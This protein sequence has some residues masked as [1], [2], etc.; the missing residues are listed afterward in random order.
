VDFRESWNLVR[1]HWVTVLTFALLGCMIA[2][3]YV[4]TTVPRYTAETELFVAVD[5]GDSTAEL[6]QGSNYSQQQARNYSAVASRQVVLDPVIT[7]LGLRTTPEQLAK[8]I[9]TS[10]PLNTSLISISVSDTSPTRAASIANAVA[11]SLT[12][13]VVKLVP[14]R[15]DGTSPIELQAIQ[16]ASVPTEPSEPNSRVALAFGLLAGILAGVALVVL[17]ERVRTKVRTVEQVKSIEGLSILG[18]IIYDRRAA[19]RPILGL[20]DGGSRRAEE[21]RQLR[22]NLRFLQ[23][24]S[25][26]KAFVVTSS[27]QG[28][29]KSTTA[30]NIAATLAASGSSVCLVEADLRKPVLQNY[31]DLEGAVGMTTVI[32]NEVTLD[33]ALQTW[34]PHRMKVLLSGELPPNP[35]ELLGSRQTES[36]LKTITERFDV[37]IIDCPPLLPVTDAALLAKSLGGAI[38]VVGTGRVEV[39]ELRRA[40]ETLTAAGAPILGAV[41]NMIP[42][43]RGRQSAYARTQQHGQPKPPTAPRRKASATAGAQPLTTR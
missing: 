20:D 41:V 15:S 19:T 38:L 7:A 10:V 30:G 27:I 24:D 12:N 13:T 17:R 34:G 35:S 22:T 42:A 23:T 4:L 28:E 14:S 2:A 6:A 8:Q 40:V 33:D 25:R 26:N 36:L 37:T 5:G 1:S 16:T 32:T 3:A 21:F 18:S 29:G 39:R 31:L 11:T 9:S 43:R